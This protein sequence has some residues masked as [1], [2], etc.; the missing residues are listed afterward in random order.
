[1]RSLTG[2]RLHSAVE[3]A[4]TTFSSMYCQTERL[5]RAYILCRSNEGDASGVWGGVMGGCFKSGKFR[6]AGLGVSFRGEP[7]NLNLGVSGSGLAE[8]GEGCL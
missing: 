1:M 3:A 7:R 2:M 8:G 6:D 5:G 4:C